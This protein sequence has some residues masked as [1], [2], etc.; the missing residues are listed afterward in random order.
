[1][2]YHTL[3]AALL[4]AVGALKPWCSTFSVVAANAWRAQV[5]TLA[6]VL[7]VGLQI[8]WVESGVGRVQQG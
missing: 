2:T 1:M 7:A 3:V 8:L 4:Q 6:A 5:A